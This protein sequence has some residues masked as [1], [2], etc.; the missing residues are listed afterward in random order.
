MLCD[1]DKQDTQ[2]VAKLLFTLAYNF[3]TEKSSSGSETLNQVS[4]FAPNTILLDVILPA[5][6]GPIPIRPSA[7]WVVEKLFR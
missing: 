5:W 3:D 2:N 1:E 6:A 7:N 4:G